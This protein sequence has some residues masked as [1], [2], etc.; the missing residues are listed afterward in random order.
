[1]KLVPALAVS[2]IG[3]ATLT[4]QQTELHE[5]K[6]TD[7]FSTDALFQSLDTERGEVTLLVPKTIPLRRLSR[8]SQN[9]L[10]PYIQKFARCTD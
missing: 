4:A 10:R 1:M 7:G 2:L 3:C 8:D 5:W 9:L 6:T